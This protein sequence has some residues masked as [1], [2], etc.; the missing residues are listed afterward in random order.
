MTAF[1]RAWRLVKGPPKLAL[2]DPPVNENDPNE[3]R[4]EHTT[5]IITTDGS[6]IARCTREKDHPAHR[7][8]LNRFQILRGGHVFSD[9]PEDGLMFSNEDV[10]PRHPLAEP[11]PAPE[12][13]GLE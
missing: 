7:N 13:E 3:Q 10:I 4:C 5:R 8:D 12:L 9:R 2:T 1:D 6:Y 11:T